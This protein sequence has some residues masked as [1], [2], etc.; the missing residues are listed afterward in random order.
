MQ[1]LPEDGKL[2]AVDDEAIDIAY[3]HRLLAQTLYQLTHFLHV[4]R[5]G[6]GAG[7]DL[8]QGQEVRGIQPMLTHKALGILAGL[9]DFCDMEAGSICAQEC[10]L[11]SDFGDLPEEALLDVHAGCTSR[12]RSEYVSAYS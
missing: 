11:R 8:A 10:F 7:N 5:A 9:G 1:G 3:H 2:D 6:L 4:F 12:N